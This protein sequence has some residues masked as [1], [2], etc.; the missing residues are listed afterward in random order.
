[1]HATASQDHLALTGE[2]AWRQHSGRR[3]H[4]RLT[5]RSPGG[6]LGTG[7]AT[8]VTMRVVVIT[9]LK[10]TSSS[11]SEPEPLSLPGTL[12]GMLIWSGT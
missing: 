11:A 5:L 6:T 3:L 9:F 8:R 12:T 7:A 4:Y 2:L 10:G 1:V